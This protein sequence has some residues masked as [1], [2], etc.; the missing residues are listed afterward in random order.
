LGWAA[1]ILLTLSAVVIASGA[2][3]GPI[4]GL[5]GVIAVLFAYRYPYATY[6]VLLALTPF[7]GLT[8]SLSTG[9]LAVGER[10]FGGSIDIQL[11]EVV[12]MSLVGAW[13]L[14]VAYLW[15]K[16]RDTNWKIWLPLGWPM[17]W[18]VAAHAASLFSPFKP[19]PVLVIKNSLR[20]VAWCYLI[21]V[22]LTVNLIRSRKRLLMAL[23][24]ITATGLFAAL[25]G[26][27]SLGAGAGPLGWRARPL[28]MLGVMPL[29][30]NHN[31][32]AEWLVVTV[33]I[34]LALALLMKDR[35][36]ARLLGVAAAFQAA[37]ALLTFARS[38]WIVLALE[39][40]CFGW[41]VWR[42]RMMRWL[43]PAL[44]AAVV[45]LPMGAAMLAFS[46]TA[47]VQSSTSTRVM[48]SEIAFSLWRES[49]WLGMGAGT[50]LDRVGST[51]VFLIEYGAPLDS[52]GWIQKLLAETGLLGLAAAIGL[53]WAAGAFTRDARARFIPHSVEWR[54]F[55]ALATGA[56]GSLVYQLFNTSY[57]TGKMWL[58][59]GIMLAASRALLER[60][61]SEK[62]S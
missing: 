30:D 40:I 38:A 47:L 42:D 6:G 51:Q 33:P 2:P 56:F 31:L 45:L 43:R 32:L 57:W 58:P 16:R 9:A 34:T 27:V 7:L 4:V 15:W 19:D 22:A 48:L 44:V 62:S 1:I 29:G 8:S 26:F 21:Y 39:A 53:V 41:F 55:T 52:H 10:A 49:P 18:L 17:A 20:P 59:L 14:K 24:V 37:I 46:S 50:F 35:R 60:H 13:A 12:A 11:A 23:G 28:S 25:M 36:N 61:D 5:V 3:L 54:A